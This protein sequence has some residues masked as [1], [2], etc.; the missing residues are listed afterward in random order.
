MKNH[1]TEDKESFRDEK[2]SS[3]DQKLA[4]LNKDDTTHFR[5]QDY[6]KRIVSSVEKKSFLDDAEKAEKAKNS[7][8]TLERDD[9]NRHIEE[10]SKLEHKRQKN[11]KQYAEEIN[12]I[13]LI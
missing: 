8:S 1:I 12:Q 4:R 5:S 3:S 10:S 13:T 6:E 9:K 7:E 2:T 11:D